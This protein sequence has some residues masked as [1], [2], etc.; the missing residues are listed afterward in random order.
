MKSLNRPALLVPVVLVLS[1]SACN[2]GQ[3]A[4]FD[5][6]ESLGEQ[7]FNDKSLSKDGTQSCATCHDSNHAFIDPRPNN[8]SS[9]P[10][11]NGMVSTGQ[12][13]QSLGDINTP[14]ATYTAFVPKFHF[15]QKEQLYKG[16]LFLNGRVADLAEKRIRSGA[17][18][19]N[20]RSFSAMR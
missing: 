8:T 13:G 3:K 5:S 15:N 1:L 14:T 9:A 10:N 20:G 4:S 16:G 19:K 2:P 7:L 11:L 12:D 6:R 17:I 18:E